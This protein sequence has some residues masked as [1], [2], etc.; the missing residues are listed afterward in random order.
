MERFLKR[1][2]DRIAGIISGFDRVAYR[3]EVKIFRNN[4]WCLF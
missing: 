2:E 1:H 3:K 4:L